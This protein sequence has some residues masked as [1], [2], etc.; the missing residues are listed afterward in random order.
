[1]EDVIA[2]ARSELAKVKPI[3]P[4]SVEAV[5]KADM[6]LDEGSKALTLWWKHI[7]IADRSDFS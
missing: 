3:D 2:S 4:S 5:R 7:K 6:S 1:M